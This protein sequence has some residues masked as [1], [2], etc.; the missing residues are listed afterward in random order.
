[1][2]SLIITQNITLDGSIEMLEEASW[3]DPHAQDDQLTAEMHRQD[4]TADAVLLGRRTF[5]DFRGYWPVQTEDSTGVTDYLNKVDKFVVSATMSDPG[6]QN[7]TIL[8]GDPIDEVRAL[9]TATGGD[10]VVTGSIT[11]CHALIAADLVDEYRL[12]VYPF[13]QGGGR[14]L[15]PDGSMMSGFAPAAAPMAFPGGVMLMR[16]S[17]TRERPAR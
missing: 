1:M 6:W 16:W 15:F 7:S 9:K 8:T 3:F 2:R 10:I 17:R 13:V 4:A 14:R 12:F 5:E 11:L